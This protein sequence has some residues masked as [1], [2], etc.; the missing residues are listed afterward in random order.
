MKNIVDVLSLI[1]SI[2][3]IMGITGLLSWSLAGKSKKPSDYAL[4]FL[5]K[6]FRA[7]ICL[8]ILSPLLY[9][10]IILKSFLTWIFGGPSLVRD[11]LSDPLVWWDIDY[12]Y[13][14]ILGYL[15]STPIALVIIVPTIT[16]IWFW[17]LSP[18]L[19]IWEYITNRK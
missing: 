16:T 9:C 17:K 14:Y 10:F 15:V 19:Q 12:P 11:S 3:T 18:F 13:S 5:G 1:S 6:A 8:I 2:M 7:A 4:S